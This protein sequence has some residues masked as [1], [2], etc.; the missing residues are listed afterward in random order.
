MKH[1]VAFTLVALVTGIALIASEK[2]KADVP[3]RP[4]PIVY[5]IADSEHEL[6]R[7]PVAFTRLS[8]EEEVRIGNELAR[9][10][11][12]RAESA[13]QARESRVVEA[14]VQKVGARVAARAHR[15]LPYKFHYVPSL[16]FI[17]AFALPGG[18]VFMGGGLVGLMDSEDELAAVLG[19]EIEHIDHY[20]CAERVQT[21][22]TLRK[23]PLGGLIAIPVEIFEAGYSK[24][25]ELEADREGTRLAV[26]ASY[27]PLGAIRM[28]EAFERLFQEHVRR[29]GTPQEEL[30][31][32]ALETLEGY[33]RSHPMPSER[34]AQIKRMIADERWGNLTRER[35]LEVAFIFWTDRARREFA[36]GHFERAAGLA[37][38]SLE[39]NPDQPA[40]LKVLGD[41]KFA[42]AD[43]E[44]AAEAYRKLLDRYP[45]DPEIVRA[46]ADALAA[47]GQPERA[48]SLFR[49][50]V[51]RRMPSG[52]YIDVELA[53][54]ELMAG[55]QILAEAIIK[56]AEDP[57]SAASGPE[58]LGRLGW[59]Y[60]RAGN[61]QL[62]ATLLQSAVNQRPGALT[63]D[64]EL[65]WAL[66]EQ[67]NFKGAIQSFY[68]SMG[69]SV[70]EWQAR[71]REEALRDFASAALN[72]PQWKNPRW[73]K[74]LYSPLVARSI[75]EMEAEQ[76]RR[77][78][79]QRKK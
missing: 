48:A 29:A 47:A 44:A 12:R 57:S 31:K 22:A 42:L 11:D 37:A 35:D 19:H 21:E 71:Q 53:G 18:H 69:R 40:A 43:F 33:F 66:I 15:K 72:Q 24:D 75:V 52:D 70:A 63:L 77:L 3:V 9:Y 41:S 50:W 65:G 20:H 68:D 38:R 54:L 13:E 46:Y 78:V 74:G 49:D 55:R 23:I 5:F 8:D 14:Y 25:Q 32:V 28:F 45:A 79:A 73:V 51:D 26:W 17:N 7:L 64:D 67:R 34:I 76:Q 62:S 10:Y 59:W 16:N 1:W 2:R 27:S 56:K 4:D 30:S 58:W 39:S 60:Y 6:S 61:Y 36:A